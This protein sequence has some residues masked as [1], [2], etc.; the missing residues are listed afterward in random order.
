MQIDLST[1]PTGPGVYLFKD[2]QN[3][4]L[5]VGKAKH[6]RR[7][8]ASY[9]RPDHSLPLKTAAML[10]QAAN[11]ETLSTNTEKEAL[12]LE[13]SL[14]KKHRPRYNIV[15]RDD[16]QYLLF[17]LDKAHPFPRLTIVRPRGVGSRKQ[18]DIAALAVGL[19]AN[20]GADNKTGKQPG[21]PAR[22]KDK[23]VFYG[24][25]TSALSAR[26]TWKIIHR[27]FPLRR[28]TN[29]SFKNRVRPCLYHHLGQCLA[30]CVLPV[31]PEDYQ[32]VLQK[33]EMF[34]SGRSAEL[35]GQLQQD[36]QRASD[37]LNFE[38]AAVLR[39]QIKAVQATLEK[40]SAVLPGVAD[41]DVIGLAEVGIKEPDQAAEGE[42]P[43]QEQALALGLLFIRQGRVIG[44]RIFFW[45]GLSM[46]DGPE[47]V[48]SFIL[49]FYDAAS[50]IPGRILLPWGDLQAGEIFTASSD[51][52]SQEKGAEFFAL[53]GADLGNRP[54]TDGAAGATGIDGAPGLAEATGGALGA[55]TAAALAGAEIEEEEEGLA[56]S[57]GDFV[58]RLNDDLQLLQEVLA[59]RRDGPVFLATPHSSE[60][61]QLVNMAATNARDA[62]KTGFG[63]EAGEGP[64]EGENSYQDN[65]ALV[66]GRK[67]Y[68]GKPV[69]RIEVVDISHT[70]G[71]EARA[72]LV[73]FENGQP[74]REDFRAYIIEDDSLARGD[75]YGALALFMRRRLNSGPPWPDLLLI[76]GGRG[77]LAAVERVLQEENSLGLFAL[78][79][80]AKA[81]QQEE[82]LSEF[83][84]TA[85]EDADNT[86]PPLL[87]APLKQRSARPDRRAGNVADRIF[88]PGRSNPLNLKPGS[89]E[90][91]FL[92][93]LRNAAHD[94][95]IGKH[96][97][98]R[99]KAAL[100]GELVRLPGIGPK[101]AQLLWQHFDS[102]AEMRKSSEADL[103]RLPGIGKARAARLWQQL[104]K[105]KS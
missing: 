54:Y 46:A 48:C 100:A 2:K 55:V 81:R 98:A 49:Q 102:L 26:E 5:Y 28:C 64:A 16:K 50:L 1:L 44:A 59:E 31:A 67:L 101:T 78:A 21:R 92:Q 18:P 27:I 105:L 77:Q 90:L 103:A 80:I 96:R 22:N 97:K 14:I 11:L 70:S 84:A 62:A 17:Y 53:P 88:I 94:Q 32:A 35:L 93:M 30:P 68:L 38:Q 66:L 37:E 74:V 87:P 9:F 63:K 65:M 6:L 36:M 86:R 45:P 33:V 4:I 25:F 8:L 95:A 12:L 41:M 79:S 85:E 89:A 3:T 40:Q 52:T 19:P 47:V 76:D 42:N 58:R 61:K 71:I 43:A 57:V 69:K 75:D 20:I 72:G 51:E 13:A 104:R 10:R 60:E 83:E 24:P 39:D 15:L 73:V 91:L 56:T 7:R 99:N 34:L 23:G 82:D 29:S